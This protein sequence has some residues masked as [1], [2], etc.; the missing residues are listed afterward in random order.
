MKSP[1]T[2]NIPPVILQS[3]PLLPHPPLIF[4]Q[5]T[6]NHTLTVRDEDTIMAA[7]VHV[8]S[9]LPEGAQLSELR[10]RGDKIGA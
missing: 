3:H 5:T 4:S 7:E 10:I 8:F 6:T 9:R 2:D 1:M